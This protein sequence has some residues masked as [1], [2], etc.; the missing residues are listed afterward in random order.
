MNEASP[1]AAELTFQDIAPGQTFEVERV[2]TVED[3]AAFATLSGDHSPLHVDPGYAAGT[4]FGG[5]VVHGILLA[6]LFSQLVGM[7]IPGKHALYLGQDLV[8]R[9]PVRVGERVRAVGKVAGKNDATRTI[10]LA[11]EIRDA[12]DK[13]AVSGSAKVK[14]RDGAAEQRP[15][16]RISS[17]AADIPPRHDGRRVAIVTGASGGVGAEVARAL[18]AKGYAVALNYLRGEERAAVVAADIRRSGGYALPIRADVRDSQDIR[19]AVEA[20]TMELGPATVLV[21]AATGAL[22]QKPFTELR[23]TDFQRDLEYQVKAVADLAQAVYP[24][25]R[26]AG[27]GAIVNLLSQVVSGPPPA[28]MAAYV[29]AKSALEGLTRALAAE[30]ADDRVRVNAVSPGLLQ[31]ELTQHYPDRVFRAEAARTPLKRLATTRDVAQAVAYLA[32]DDGGFLTGVNLFVTGG[33]VML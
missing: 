28:N 31:T 20:V 7:R 29:V 23:W 19:R 10:T 3:V 12:G 13:V 2:F 17:T 6:S 1:R 8:F 26:A 25:M 32:S 24:L 11:T 15:E 33:Q 30:W 14:L 21:N 16:A 27:G 5:C 4:E 18:A 9:R 22:E